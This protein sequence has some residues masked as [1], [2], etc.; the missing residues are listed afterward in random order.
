MCVF[1]CSADVIGRATTAPLNTVVKCG[2]TQEQQSWSYHEMAQYGSNGY[3]YIVD[4][5]ESHD[6]DDAYFEL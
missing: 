2:N 1:V 5:Y 3:T 4:C 6:R